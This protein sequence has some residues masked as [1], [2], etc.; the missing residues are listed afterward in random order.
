MELFRQFL[1]SKKISAEKFQQAE[2]KRFAEWESLFGQV[3]DASFV[4]QK[5][6]LIN[7]IRCKYQLEKPVLQ[8]VEQ[9]AAKK[10]RPVLARKPKIQ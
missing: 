3:S 8:P 5:L 9:S 1:E 10:N 2:P 4:A 7:P 6:F